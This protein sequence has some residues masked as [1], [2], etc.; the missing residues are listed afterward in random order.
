MIPLVSR[1]V[2]VSRP[3]PRIS[4][5]QP[6][7]DIVI[8]HR[9]RIPQAGLSDGVVAELCAAVTHENPDK[10]K[11]AALRGPA[12][13]AAKRMPEFI[14]LSAIEDG[15]LS[16]PRGALGKVR[17]VLGAAGRG[18]RYIDRRERGAP[19]SVQ[20]APLVHRPD[21]SAAD[22]GALRWYQQEAVE[23]AVKKQN[24]LLRAPTGSGKTS[25]L[26][27]LI[28]R[29]SVKTL[30]VV[31]SSE[32]ARQWTQRLAREL[33]VPEAWI[34]MVGG[35]ERRVGPITVG[36]RQ[37]LS[38]KDMSVAAD[39]DQALADV[40]LV[41]VDEVHRAAASTFLEVVDRFPAFYRV[42][43]SA[44]ETRPDGKEF[45]VYDIFGEVAH[46]VSQ[47]E[48]IDAG[49][50][51]DVECRVIPTDF[52]APWYVEQRA[53][54]EQPDFNRLLDEMTTDRAR[55]QIATYWAAHLVDTDAQVMVLSHRVDHAFALKGFVDQQL[56][57]WER[58]R[59]TAVTIGGPEHAEARITGVDGLRAGTVRA[60]FGTVQ[61]MGTAV[62]IP[63]VTAGMLVTPI[64]KN[65]QLYA[66][67]RG[68]IC[69]P[70]AGKACAALY[71]LWDPMISGKTALKR[72]LQWNNVVL[73]WNPLTDEWVDGAVYLAEYEREQ[74]KEQAHA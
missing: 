58:P 50:V 23:A 61:A 16:L 43:A 62:D 66:Q 15:T 26:I 68:R 45:I 52:E 13:F 53:R 46:E 67:V 21:A 56:R 35:G 7:I 32:L 54:G 28:A 11:T 30:V 1:P 19:I 37:S 71:V 33:A 27:G 63:S 22:G 57:D 69:R 55:N 14:N 25:T 2:R 40:G 34:G 41:V 24:C 31:D 38:P 48:L 47:A 4:G 59:E 74:Q 29:L 17:A 8:D 65:R 6:I 20:G 12:R 36:M 18:W 73:V 5:S 70:A 3:A 9:L 60:A 49:A 72:L 51:L 44:D 10:A 64:G 42:G 39:L